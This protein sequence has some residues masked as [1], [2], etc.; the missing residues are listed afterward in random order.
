[1]ILIFSLGGIEMLQAQ[2][3]EAMRFEGTLGRST[4][5][6][7][8]P[9]AG[10]SAG[11][12]KITRNV[13]NKSKNIKYLCF[14]DRLNIVH[15]K[16]DVLF[17]DPKPATIPGIG[18]VFYNCKPTVDGPSLSAVINDACINK[19]SPIIVNGSPVNQTQGMWLARGAANGDIEFNNDGYLQNAYNNGK[20][21]QFWFTPITLDQFATNPFFE[22][23]ASN[24]AGACIAVNKD[25]AFSIVYLNALVMTNVTASNNGLNNY[26]GTFTVTG[27]LPEFD[28]IA[29]YTRI[30]IVNNKD[31]NLK[32]RLTNGPATNGKAMTFSVPQPGTYDILIEDINGCSI[33][34]RITIMEDPGLIKLGC[35]DGQIGQEVCFPISIGR[36]PDLTAAQF[37][38]GF[39]PQSLEYVGAKNLNPI[40]QTTV[41]N[42]IVTNSVAQGFIKFFWVDFNLNSYDFTNELPLVELCFKIKGP[43]G[44]NTVRILPN[45]GPTL[46]RLE[47][48]DADGN[49][50]P[51]N[52][53]TGSV[54]DCT[55]N[56][57]PSSDL[58]ANYLQCGQTLFGQVFGGAGP[59]AIRYKLIANP[60]V[61]DTLSFAQALAPTPIF[62][63][64]ASGAYEL[65]AKDATGSS[66]TDTFTISSAITDISIDF[67]NRAN[68]SCKGKDGRILAAVTGGTPA[69]RFEWS[70]NSVSDRITNL[71]P[72]TYTVKITDAQG[73]VKTDSVTL[74]NEGVQA[75]YTIDR[76]PRCSGV[77]DGRV[78][79]NPSGAFPPFLANWEGAGTQI[80]NNFSSVSEIP[81]RLIVRDAKG[82]SDT[83][84]YFS[85]A[86]QKH[87]NL[88]LTIDNPR[89]FGNT[90]G[91]LTIGRTFSDG[92][93]MT[94]DQVSLS[95]ASIGTKS[96]NLRPAIFNNLPAGIY[97]VRVAESSGCFIDTVINLVQPKLLDT[98]NV[99]S[100]FE[101]CYPAKDG[102][103]SLAM[104]GG[105]P[106]YRYTWSDTPINLGSRTGL[107]AGSYKVT[108]T[109]TN[110]CRTKFSALNEL[111]IN[112]RQSNTGVIIPI[113][114]DFYKLKYL[115]AQLF[116]VLSNDNLLPGTPVVVTID[117]PQNGAIIY[118]Q[119]TG[120]GTFTPS[121]TFSG[122][123]VLNYKVC[124]QACPEVCSFSK[125]EFEI[126]SPCLD[127]N[128]LV[129]PNVIFPTGPSGEN[130][131]FFVEA[132]QNCPGAFGPKPTKLTVYNRWGNLVFHTDDYRNNWEGTNT[133]GLPLPSGTYY[134]LLDLGSINAPIK[135][136]VV[137]MR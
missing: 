12:F 16:V 133:Q 17:Q 93:L 92:S 111:S 79:A 131:Y 51:I 6:R 32:G 72:G 112:L 132:L 114:P 18:Y 126:E 7:S 88:S 86:V 10:T 100:R 70:T 62:S 46:P 108:I 98:I 97:N 58:D 90:D 129:L 1:M 99:V 11:T 8:A 26:T 52:T 41:D 54:F 45:P 50:I 69:Y 2:R 14:G 77:N 125:I 3:P 22:P 36:I 15:N 27:G 116:D 28:P 122:K 43:P 23:N 59:Y 13:L 83:T 96:D 49:S 110:N 107:S 76:L 67:S 127:R 113:Q 61:T 128:H 4:G 119:S 102:Q 84:P 68:I 89:C 9:C 64:L 35:M 53:A 29:T 106:P 40:L 25:S 80:G 134:Y 44:P 117:N 5:F 48:S 19:K 104:T 33:T 91:R 24:V 39:N 137:I 123:E 37:T 31:A 65:I 101:S 81:I 38:V 63:N 121:R 103:I 47:L 135:G 74:I 66:V 21:V 94:G 109:E 42:T 85:L 75:A 30:S 82:C 55:M 20:P 56:I 105:T 95:S 57:T 78:L 73:C 130:R 87:I 115:T 136:Y 71:G 34:E 124:L 118:S 120:K 60:A